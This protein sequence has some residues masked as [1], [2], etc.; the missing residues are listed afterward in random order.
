MTALL[1]FAGILDAMDAARSLVE[2]WAGW[3]KFASLT[4]SAC[5]LVLACFATAAVT[6]LLLGY[7]AAKEAAA[8]EK[9]VT[10]SHI[11]TT[12]TDAPVGAGSSA[13]PFRVHNGLHTQAHRRRS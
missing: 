12:A 4:L 1:Y 13:G 5:G 3:L 7:T 9:F 10:E 8:R 6:V 2:G 11:R